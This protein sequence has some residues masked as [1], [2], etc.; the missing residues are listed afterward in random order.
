MGDQG[1]GT[2]ANA[3]SPGDQ[4][5]MVM[6]TYQGSFDT[7]NYGANALA[8]FEFGYF[9]PV[10]VYTQGA[11][12]YAVNGGPVENPAAPTGT[13]SGN[14]ISLD[15]GA[16][17]IEWCCYEIN[18]GNHNVTGSYDSATGE[19]AVEWSSLIDGGPFNGN[20]GYWRLNGIATVSAVPVPAAVWLMGSGLAGL[21]AVARR[22]KI[23]GL[24]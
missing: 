23:N 24:T 1:F 19:Y 17:T 10:D 8:T 15:L 14:T 2:Y 18:Q 20:I 12:A 9:G 21:I 5:A 16:W 6:G 11:N 22:R 7:G 3:L 4:G 13:T